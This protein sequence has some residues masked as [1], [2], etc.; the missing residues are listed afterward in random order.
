MDEIFFDEFLGGD[1]S[2]CN[3]DGI[4]VMDFVMNVGK[5]NCVVRFVWFG[6]F[7]NLKL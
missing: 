6:Y 1:K 5:C 2:I 3:N 4:Y 7:R